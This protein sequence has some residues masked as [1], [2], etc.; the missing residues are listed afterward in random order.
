MLHLP[1]LLSLNA[2]WSAELGTKLVQKLSTKN[3]PELHFPFHPQP[4]FYHIYNYV[5]PLYCNEQQYGCDYLINLHS[6][7][8]GINDSRERMKVA[9]HLHYVS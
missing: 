6:N 3:I 7:L 5:K 2:K 9:C 4:H 1:K 8:L